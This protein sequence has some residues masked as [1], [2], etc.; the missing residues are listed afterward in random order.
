MGT[1]IVLASKSRARYE[2]LKSLGFDVEVV[3]PHAK[4]REAKFPKE[5]VSV[6]VD[7]SYRKAISVKAKSLVVAA[8]T[9]VFDENVV[10]GKPSTLEEARE[11]IL[12]LNGRWHNVVTGLSV[13]FPD[14]D[15]I[16]LYDIARV[17]FR[18]LSREEIEFYISTK[19][20]LGKAGGYRIQGL[21]ALLVEKIYGHHS[22]I[23]GLPVHRLVEALLEKGYWPPRVARP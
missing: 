14:G 2:L 15:I 21:G 7:N 20:S 9:L 8:D 19:E 3:E 16:S 1:R 6:V 11:M 4:E 12:Y 5:V 18:V 17:K 13:V 23:I 10:F 22:T